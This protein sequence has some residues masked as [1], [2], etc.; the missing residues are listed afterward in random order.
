MGTVYRCDI[1]KAKRDIVIMSKFNS[2]FVNNSHFEDHKHW[3]KVRVDDMIYNFVA[4]SINVSGSS[5]TMDTYIRFK[6]KSDY[7]YITQF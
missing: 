5:Y 2:L 7:F 3:R 4:M 6:Q 1:N